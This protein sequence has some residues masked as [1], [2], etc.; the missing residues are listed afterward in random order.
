[1]S[2]VRGSCL[3]GIKFEIAG[4]LLGPINCHC[5]QCRKQHGAAFRSPNPGRCIRL[6]LDRE[7]PQYP[8]YPPPIDGKRGG[9]LLI[10][11]RP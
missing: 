7:L 6:P 1:M 10:N 3:C 5:S 9:T 4:P 2:P 11:G 8:D